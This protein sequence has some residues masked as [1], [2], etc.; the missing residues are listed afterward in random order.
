MT[1]GTHIFMENGADLQ[2]PGEA[3]SPESYGIPF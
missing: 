1:E 2:I 3:D